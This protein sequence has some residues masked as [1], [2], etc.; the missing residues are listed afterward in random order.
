MDSLCLLCVT[1]A[2]FS[3]TLAFNP[4]GDRLDRLHSRMRARAS[5]EL[6]RPSAPAAAPSRTTQSNKFK[7]ENP[8]DDLVESG[9]D[10]IKFVKNPAGEWTPSLV[11]QEYRQFDEEEEAEAIRRMLEQHMSKGVHK[12]GQPINQFINRDLDQILSNH[13][14]LDALRR[15]QR[16]NVLRHDSLENPGTTAGKS[17]SRAYHTRHRSTTEINTGENLP[18]KQSQ[19]QSATTVFH[20]SKLRTN[21]LNNLNSLG[22]LDNLD[23]LDSLVKST[24]IVE[25][26]DQQENERVTAL[27]IKLDTDNKTLTRPGYLTIDMLRN[28]IKSTVQEAIEASQLGLYTTSSTANQKPKTSNP[29]RHKPHL[30]NTFNKQPYSS[31]TKFTHTE[32]PPELNTPPTGPTTTYL[33]NYSEALLGSSLV[34]VDGLSDYTGEFSTVFLGG[35]N[36]S[37]GVGSPSQQ[38]TSQTSID[39]HISTAAQSGKPNPPALS[40]KGRPASTYMA[41]DSVSSYLSTTSP[42]HNDFSPITSAATTAPTVAIISTSRASPPPPT[43]AQ[44]ITG[45]YSR[46]TRPTNAPISDSSTTTLSY[47]NLYGPLD[48]FLPRLEPQFPMPPF[49]ASSRITELLKVPDWAKRPQGS[50]R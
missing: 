44:L 35:N 5:G 40:I 19:T 26:E 41:P 43:H 9:T 20:N 2:L 16:V 13:I 11:I 46:S 31:K 24:G 42:Q 3:A 1:C 49:P 23:S 17:K 28:L 48:S 36:D 14:G 45:A 30:K 50:A 8:V 6:V 4:I 25:T 12:L 22:S 21:N 32:N 7:R 47:N 18:N 37:G 34:G 15:R 27:G 29:S 38:A 10:V 39:N 33:T